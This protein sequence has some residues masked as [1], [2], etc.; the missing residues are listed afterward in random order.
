MHCL[1]L[2]MLLRDAAIGHS[3]AKELAF[4][5]QKSCFYLTVP[6]SNK[7]HSVLFGRAYL[8]KPSATA[9]CFGE[10]RDEWDKQIIDHQLGHCMLVKNCLLR[11]GDGQSARGP[12]YGKHS[13]CVLLLALTSAMWC[14]L[15]AATCDIY[16]V[17]AGYAPSLRP[18]HTRAHCQRQHSDEQTALAALQTLGLP[19]TYRTDM[20][21]ADD[22]LRHLRLVCRTGQLA[23]CTEHLSH[24]E[25]CRNARGG[26]G[27]G[28]ISLS[29]GL[30]LAG[31]ASRQNTCFMSH[32]R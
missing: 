4:S 18:C 12:V 22:G 2:D 6:R 31:A 16:S 23:A 21:V 30:C 3:L 29:C 32:L 17:G 11:M 27:G 25:R 9:G 10:R 1:D 7:R 26:G 28:G 8:S 5:I 24:A 14:V 15:H 13:A 19:S 20:Y